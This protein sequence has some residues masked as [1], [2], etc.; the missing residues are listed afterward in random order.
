[1]H[2]KYERNATFSNDK[3]ETCLVQCDLDKKTP[4]HGNI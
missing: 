4:N 1:M 2:L 3:T